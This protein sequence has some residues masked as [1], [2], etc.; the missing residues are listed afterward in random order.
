MV[1]KIFAILLI[2]FALFGKGSLDLL[3][4]HPEP[5]PVPP[6][7]EILNIDKPSEDI[8][9][10]VKNFSAIITDPT[11]RAKLAIFNY[12]FAQNVLSYEANSQQVNDVYVLA[13]KNFFQTSIAGKYEQ[14]DEMIIKLLQDII[15]TDNHILTEKEKL[16]LNK[17]FTA[18]A[19][20]LIQKA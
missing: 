18:I 9:D 6:Q 2:I 15:G 13:G 8:I 16:D 1:K 12:Q 14:L 10:K 20:V 5:Q 11:D 17:Y 7:A 3:D 19:W 4:N